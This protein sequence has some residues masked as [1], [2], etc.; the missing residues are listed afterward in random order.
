VVFSLYRN[1]KT[2]QTTTIDSQEYHFFIGYSIMII[3]ENKSSD[4]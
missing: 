2:K 3:Y 4:I 1:A